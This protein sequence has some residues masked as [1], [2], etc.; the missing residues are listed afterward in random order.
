[1]FLKTFEKVR[2]M[3]KKKDKMLRILKIVYGKF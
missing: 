2:P 1:M 3:K